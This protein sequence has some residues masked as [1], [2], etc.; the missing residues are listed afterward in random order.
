MSKHITNR[1]REFNMQAFVNNKGEAVAV[2]NSNR[3]ARGD[4]LGPGGKVIATSQQITS[5]V[6]NRK[7]TQASTM[8]KLNPMEQEIS[9]KE[10]IGADGVP[11]WEITYADGSI[12]IQ[13]KLETKIETR[14]DIDSRA[15]N[16]GDL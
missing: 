8:V 4:L 2:G 14:V 10:I 3:N 1:G 9:K 11:R 12:E 6:Y 5:E 15:G 7:S 16:K 13:D